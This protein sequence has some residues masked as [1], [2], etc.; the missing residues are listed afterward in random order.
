MEKER[1]GSGWRLTTAVPAPRTTGGQGEPVIGRRIDCAAGSGSLVGQPVAEIGSLIG[2]I[3]GHFD[4][5]G[6]L[7]GPDAHLLQPS[8]WRTPVDC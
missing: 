2:R 4:K 3:A 7:I 5:N 6:S 1:R 8:I